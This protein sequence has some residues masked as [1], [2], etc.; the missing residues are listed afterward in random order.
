MVIALSWLC[1]RTGRD[2]GRKGLL[3]VAG[4]AW[5]KKGEGSMWI[6]SNIRGVFA[7][8]ADLFLTRLLR[9]NWSGAASRSWSCG[10]NTV[11]DQFDLVL[12][13]A[14]WP[15]T[16]GLADNID[17][18]EKGALIPAESDLG[19]LAVVEGDDVDLEA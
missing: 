10:S 16:P 13:I 7:G 19:D 11:D 4:V 17:E 12:S 15:V 5:S 14:N 2:D 3:G 9:R 6:A 8:S 1:G 18:L